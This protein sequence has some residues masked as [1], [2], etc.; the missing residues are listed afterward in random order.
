MQQSWP[1]KLISLCVFFGIIL[2]L[3]GVIGWITSDN[4]ASWYG[5]LNHPAITPPNWIFGPVWTLLYC[6]IAISGW[7][8]YQKNKLYGRVLWV[9]LI[10]LV[11]N[12][13][14]S[15]IFFMCHQIGL[16]LLEIALLWGVILVNI[17]IFYRYSKVSAFLLIPYLLWVSFALCL[18]LSFWLIN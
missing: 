11:L 2:L 15:L 1:R 7:L 3:S 10:Q 4:I 13:C 12:F 8:V 14:W 9:Y 5:L 18:N 17:L 16:A 6:M